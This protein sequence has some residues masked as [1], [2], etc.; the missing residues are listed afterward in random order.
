MM[1][2]DPNNPV[3]K[4]CAEGIQ[5]EM[6]GKVEDALNFYMQ[7]WNLRQDD[8]DACIVSHY[9]ARLQQTPQDILHWNQESLNYARRVNDER[10]RSFYPS[11]YLNL[12][13]SHEDLGHMDEARKYYQMA[14]DSLAVLPEG[15]Y[16]DVVK[17]GVGEGLKRVH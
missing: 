12:G 2:I 8:Y 5:A 14:A 9:V 11:L 13:K 1:E 17:R 3:V 7:A 4:L 16:A 10:V 6:S 15:Q